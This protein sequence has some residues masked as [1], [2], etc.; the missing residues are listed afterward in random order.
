[1]NELRNWQPSVGW[2]PPNCMRCSSW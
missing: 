2:Q 1:L